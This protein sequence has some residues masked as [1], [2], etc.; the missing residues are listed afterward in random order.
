MNLTVKLNSNVKTVVIFVVL[1]ICFKINDIFGFF[2][3]NML[4]VVYFQFVIQLI[5]R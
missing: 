2:I 5:M 3:K 4:L 1:K